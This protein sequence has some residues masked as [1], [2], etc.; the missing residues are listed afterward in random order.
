MFLYLLVETI[1][2]TFTFAALISWPS[3]FIGIGLWSINESPTASN[4]LTKALV[5]SPSLCTLA[6]LVYGGAFS[7]NSIPDDVDSR[8]NIVY[9][10][11]AYQLIW[12]GLLIWILNEIRLA[13]LSFMILQACLSY[14]AVFFVSMAVTNRWI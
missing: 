1:T 6:L 4:P 5:F 11:F 10:L 9:L 7:V 12:S 13:T 2:T 8:L 3:L 14:V